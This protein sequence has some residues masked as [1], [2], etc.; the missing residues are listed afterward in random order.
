MKSHMY[1][2]VNTPVS[3]DVFETKLYWVSQRNGSA[4]YIDKFGYSNATV[5][6]TGLI[7]PGGIRI[8]HHLR[9]D[10]EGMY[11]HNYL[12]YLTS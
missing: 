2:T 8:Y 5:L 3:L 11:H 1:F 10:L 6:Q 4:L 7:F 9:V 12:A